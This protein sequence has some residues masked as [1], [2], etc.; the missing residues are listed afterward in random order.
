MSPWS[1]C[2]YSNSHSGYESIG[3]AYV[4]TINRKLF[5]FG[6]PAKWK[7]SSIFALSSELHS[8]KRRAAADRRANLSIYAYL[9]LY[10]SHVQTRSHQLRHESQHRNNYRHHHLLQAV[11]QQT[12]KRQF[13]LGQKK[14]KIDSRDKWQG[15]GK[16][17]GDKQKIR[18]HEYF[19]KNVQFHRIRNRA[20]ATKS[21]QTNCFSKRYEML[22]EIETTVW[23]FNNFHLQK[24]AKFLNIALLCVRE[25]SEFS[26]IIQ[27]ICKILMYK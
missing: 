16:G 4:A 15:V 21:I 13:Q 2:I 8:K 19:E 5:H 11:C 25:N 23:N 10:V 27:V 18:K 1:T 20:E 22:D 7:L 26:D 9:C 3:L 24:H 12:G 17:G 14:L 6:P